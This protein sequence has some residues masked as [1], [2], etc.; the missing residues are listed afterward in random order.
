MILVR[1]VCLGV[2]IGL[3]SS[4]AISAEAIQTDALT[5]FAHQDPVLSE[6][7]PAELEPSTVARLPELSVA[8][9]VSRRGLPPS[10]MD[11]PWNPRICI[12]C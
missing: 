4:A 12:G 9:D 7:R 10:K 3:C 1:A 2:A 5:G 8:A 11:K 6:K